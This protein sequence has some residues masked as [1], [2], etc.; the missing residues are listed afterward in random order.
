[1]Q[2]LLLSMPDS[3]EHTPTLAIRMPN[4]ALASLAGNVDPHHHVADRRPVL[5][6]SSVRRTVERLVRD[7]QPG[8]RRPVG[9]DVSARHGAADHLADPVAQARR[10]HRR[11]RLRPEPGA[12]GVDPPDL[13][14][15]FIVRGEGE[16][17]FRELRARPRRADAARST[18]PDSGFATRQRLSAEPRRGRA[19]L[20]NGARSGRRTAA[21]ARA[22]RL[23]DAGPQRRR[24]RD[25]ARVHL[26]L[27]LLLDHRDA[28]AQ[29]P[30]LPDRAR[31]STTFATRGR[32]AR[33]RSSSSTTTSRSTS[34]ASR[35]SAGP[36]STPASTTS[37]T[38]C[39]G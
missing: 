25:L 30:P 2:I 24:R 19:A 18:S 13:G 5:V 7:L 32:A 15:D 9:D 22:L 4:G 26:R 35:R 16:M 23:H 20:A 8:S 36:S 37:T 3:F 38:W 14:V 39:R 10:P 11:R 21:R 31:A 27:Q 12:G 29:L 34:R 17:T 6:Q 28:R 33:A 1:M